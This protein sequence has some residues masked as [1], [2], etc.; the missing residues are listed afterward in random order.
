M[1]IKVSDIFEITDDNDILYTPAHIHM[2]EWVDTDFK[3]LPDD[4]RE[5]AE[6][7]WTEEKIRTF[8]NSMGWNNGVN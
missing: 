7:E 4:V 6:V 1:A 5:V 3:T 8:K 2:E